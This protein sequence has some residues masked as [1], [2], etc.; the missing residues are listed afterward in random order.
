M[1]GPGGNLVNCAHSK[2]CDVSISPLV[3]LKPIKRNALFPDWNCSDVRT[4]FRIETIAVHAKV[5]R[6]VPEPYQARRNGCHSFS[7]L[8]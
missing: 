4:D 8:A 1:F 7:G 3:Q 6:R 2:F 5:M